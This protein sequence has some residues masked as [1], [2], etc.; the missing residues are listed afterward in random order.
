MVDLG[1]P[2]S[3]SSLLIRSA[4]S[5]KI[6]TSLVEIS[7]KS[8][9]ESNRLTP[10]PMQ[11]SWGFATGNNGDTHKADK[12][13]MYSLLMI[14]LGYSILFGHLGE[15]WRFI[16]RPKIDFVEKRV[17]IGWRRPNVK[18]GSIHTGYTDYGTAVTAAQ[19]VYFTYTLCELRLAWTG[20]AATVY[21][22]N[23]YGI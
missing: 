12:N 18:L 16:H 13:F 2:Y 3:S 19:S 17:P 11:L 15:F 5:E 20:Y 22:K 10:S 9:G 23:T 1:R 7:F 6:G 14:F 21:L 4:T 8:P